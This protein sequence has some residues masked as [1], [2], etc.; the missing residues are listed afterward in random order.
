MSFGGEGGGGCREGKE[1]DDGANVAVGERYHIPHAVG[2]QQRSNSTISVMRQGGNNVS[3]TVDRSAKPSWQRR[4]NRMDWRRTRRRGEGG[5]RYATQ[6]HV[7][8]LDQGRG[9][10]RRRSPRS[11][12]I[13]SLL[14]RGYKSTTPSAPFFLLL[15]L[16]LLLL[17]KNSNIPIAP[18]YPS[19]VR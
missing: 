12:T 18:P 5:G 14:Q 8:G 3:D 6:Q 1:E 2:R 19:K 9:M 4:G 10:R 13:R 16:L 7:L 15:L 11:R 17:V